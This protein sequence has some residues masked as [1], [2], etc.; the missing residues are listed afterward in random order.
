MCVYPESEQ[1][2]RRIARGVERQVLAVTVLKTVEV[3]AVAVHRPAGQTSMDAHERICHIFYVMVNS[4]PE[5]DF[6][7]ANLVSTSPLYLAFTA[8]TYVSYEGFW[9]NFIYST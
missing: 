5:V 2:E 4:G 6:H 3:S 8:C 7:C 1:A 9:K